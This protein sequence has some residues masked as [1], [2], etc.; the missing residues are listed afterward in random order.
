MELNLLG[1]TEVFKKF[2][3]KILAVNIDDSPTPLY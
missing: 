3:K 2:E 1:V